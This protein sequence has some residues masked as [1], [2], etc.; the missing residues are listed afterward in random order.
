MTISERIQYIR[1]N[2]HGKK[3]SREEFGKCL[4]LTKDAIYNIEDAEKRLPNGIS[5]STINLICKTF[6]V[7]QEWLID[8]EG[9]V[10]ETDV[11]YGRINEMFKD[12][13][14]FFRA[15]M[16]GLWSMDDAAW[17]EFKNAVD[18]LD[19]MKKGK[20]PS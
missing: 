8:G 17:E 5:P 9:P 11:A 7:R 12:R 14:E 1:E 19:E 3:M 18:M 10:Y 2:V 20:T 4:G 16:R 6:N 15:N 13:T